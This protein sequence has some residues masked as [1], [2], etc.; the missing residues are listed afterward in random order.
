MKKALWVL[1]VIVVVAG[2]IYLRDGSSDREPAGNGSE[3]YR[4][5]VEVLRGPMCP[6]VREGEECPDAPYQTTVEVLGD[7]EVGF[8]D[9]YVVGTY[10]TDSEGRFMVDLRSGSYIFTPLGGN[11]FPACGSTRVR[12]PEGSREGIVLNCD[13]GIR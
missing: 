12:V 11:P 3:L 2:I 1:I 9:A 5:A 4:V 8:G 7:P 13:T 6:V 10:E